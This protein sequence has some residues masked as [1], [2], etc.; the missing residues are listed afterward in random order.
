MGNSD[1]KAQKKKVD[2][3]IDNK[4]SDVH[5]NSVSIRELRL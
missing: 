1:Q 3:Y 5:I 2:Y 4:W